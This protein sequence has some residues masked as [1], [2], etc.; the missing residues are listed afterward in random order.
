MDSIFYTK[1][2]VMSIILL[3][4]LL[5]FIIIL[6]ICD[7]LHLLKTKCG[8][9]KYIMM[10]LFIYPYIFIWCLLCIIL[11]CNVF[12]YVY[13]LHFHGGVCLLKY[14]MTLYNCFFL[15]KILFLLLYFNINIFTH[16]SLSVNLW[17][18]LYQF[19]FYLFWLISVT[20]CYL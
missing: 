1:I 5:K 16:L 20:M 15:R 12:N 14:N 3:A 6:I 7:F 4:F 13:K 2:W 18:N 9:V 19:Y 8:I 10:F 11:P 17:L